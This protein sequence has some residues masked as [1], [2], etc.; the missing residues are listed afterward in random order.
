MRMKASTIIELLIVMII[1][2]IVIGLTFEGVDIFRR[3]SRK[4]TN[5]IV[6]RN[7]LLNQYLSLQ[8]IIGKSDSLTLSHDAVCLHRKGTVFGELSVEDS[9]LLLHFVNTTDTLPIKVVSLDVSVG[10]QTDTLIVHTETITL[11]FNTVEQA[12][13]ATKKNRYD[14]GN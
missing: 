2:G 5:E 8:T 4:I 13:I 9:L 1:T 14:E 11:L 3:Y 10:T 6:T 7:D 12:E